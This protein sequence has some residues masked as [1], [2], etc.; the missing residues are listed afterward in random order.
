MAHLFFFIPPLLLASLLPAPCNALRKWLA[1]LRLRLCGLQGR[2]SLT[3]VFSHQH[4]KLIFVVMLPLLG[5]TFSRGEDLKA[6]HTTNKQKHAL[7]P[8]RSTSLTAAL[9]SWSKRHPSFMMFLT[10]VLLLH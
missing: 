3:S 1:F 2:T 6:E 10:A 4:K 5:H 8:W 9:F 7:Y